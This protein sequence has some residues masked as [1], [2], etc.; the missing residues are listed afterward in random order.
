MIL[1]SD[2]M[3]KA[4]K[5][6]IKSKR[7]HHVFPIFLIIISNL[8]QNFPLK[9]WVNLNSVIEC[10]FEPQDDQEFHPL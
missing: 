7:N 6:S 9:Y 3:Y 8:S 5:V 4:D 1:I 10:N 2:L